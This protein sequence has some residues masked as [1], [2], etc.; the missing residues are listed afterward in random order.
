MSANRSNIAWHLENQIPG[1]DRRAI[2]MLYEKKVELTNAEIKALRALPKEL[3]TAPGANKLIEFISATLFLNYGSDG[4][5]ESEDNLAIE[6]DDGGDAAVSE[7]IDM[8]GFI[9]QTADTIT[10]AIPKND[11]IDAAADIVNKNLALVNTGDG[12][13]GGNT[14][15]DTTMTVMVS[16]RILDFN[17]KHPRFDN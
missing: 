10:R 1:T 13:F 9:D 11:A 8:T 16:Y 12:E 3:V 17:V 4:L 7:A 15:A 2:G 5:T 6:Y 14:N